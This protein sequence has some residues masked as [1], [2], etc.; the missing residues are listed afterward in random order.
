MTDCK[1][2]FVKYR[3]LK[4]HFH[5]HHKNPSVTTVHYAR[6]QAP[7]E[8]TNCQKQCTDL[9]DLLAHLRSHLSKSELVNCPFASCGKIFKTWSSFT[10]HISRIHKHAIAGQL[11][12]TCSADL[13]H[14][15]PAFDA[16]E[17]DTGENACEDM[18]SD[19]DMRAIAK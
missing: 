8:N 5:R 16:I 11:F 9:K 2:I 17:S 10:S 14:T 6:S 1:R 7:C 3:A 19:T 4:T 13:V 18:P 15:E 12:A